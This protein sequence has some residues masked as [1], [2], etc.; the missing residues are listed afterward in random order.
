[1]KWVNQVE[2]LEYELKLTTVASTTVTTIPRGLGPCGAPGTCHSKLPSS[3]VTVSGK[4]EVLGRLQGQICTS[5]AFVG[6][7]VVSLP[8]CFLLSPKQ[9]PP[10]LCLVLA[11]CSKTS[12]LGPGET[13]VTRKRKGH[14][15]TLFDLGVCEVWR[16][17][18]S[19]GRDRTWFLLAR[20]GPVL[21]RCSARKAQAPTQTFLVCL[22]LVLS[23]LP[24]PSLSYLDVRA[25]SLRVPGG[26]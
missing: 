9:R 11:L 12:L 14:L 8:L 23:Q 1:M 21:W 3:H 10:L 25:V 22:R 4:G 17:W 15:E 19:V 5:R 13:L 6:C 24:S 16:Q 26:P 18:L 2:Y 20:R 7:G